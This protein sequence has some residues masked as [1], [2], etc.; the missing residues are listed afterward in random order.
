MNKL[1]LILLALCVAQV[2]CANAFQTSNNYKSSTWQELFD[3]FMEGAQFDDLIENTTDCVHTLEI[4]YAD[5]SEAVNHL[6]V[7]GYSWEN[8]LDFLGSIGDFSPITR[9]CFDVVGQTS[10]DLKDHF[11]RFD[12]FVDYATQILQNAKSHFFDW[13]TI[14]TKITDAVS[15]NRPKEV[16]F[17]VGYAFVLLFNFKPNAELTTQIYTEVNIPNLEWLADLLEGFLN[18]TRILSSDNIKKCINETDFAVD[19][20][21]DANREFKKGTDEGFRNGVIEL[22]DVFEHLL[23]WQTD[24]YDGAADI[25]K[26]VLQ[27]YNSFESPLDILY[28]AIRHSSEISIDFVSALQNFKNEKWEALGKNVGDIFFNI[29]ATN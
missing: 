8:Y 25:K 21:T 14:Y 17:Q 27:Y 1:L 29:F 23:P 15:R 4:G 6:Y 16:A 13:Y 2:M 7:R 12:G 19:S 20:V 9:S 22:T 26:I 10:F 18:G 28:N 24:C 5:V 3:S 11:S